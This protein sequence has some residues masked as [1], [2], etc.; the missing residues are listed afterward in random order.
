MKRG[1]D[2]IL[3]ILG[4]HY[5]AELPGDNELAVV[6]KDGAE[7]PNETIDTPGSDGLPHKGVVRIGC[8]CK[9][10]STASGS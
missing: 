3:H 5:R 8:P 4:L 10:R 6:V 1:L 7:V 9:S 2:S